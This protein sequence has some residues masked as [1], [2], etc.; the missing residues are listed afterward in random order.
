MSTI[1]ITINRIDVIGYIWMPGNVPCAQSR[2]LTSHD[3]E[4]I[5][6]LTRDNIQAWIDSHFGDFS[7]IIDFRADIGDFL[8]EWSE[9][10][11]EYTFSDC[12]Y[13]VEED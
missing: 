8:S 11:S 5:G 1:T 2:D 3:I 6:E 12:M 7:N 10:E 4:N 9:E 13:P